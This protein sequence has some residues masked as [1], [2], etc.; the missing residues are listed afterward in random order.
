[1]L[2]TW[3]K[4]SLRTHASIFDDSDVRAR[5]FEDTLTERRTSV[6][7]R[8]GLNFEFR[9]GSRG[10]RGGGRSA[11]RA[12]LN[13]E[14]FISGLDFL[15]NTNDSTELGLHNQLRFPQCKDEVD[16]LCA[17]AQCQGNFLAL[18]YWGTFLHECNKEH[19]L[20][21]HTLSIDWQKPAW[22]KK[23][24]QKWH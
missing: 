12:S 1:M 13:S 23:V 5:V 6:E 19:S 18:E 16:R 8:H 7:P 15:R 24:K 22:V 14:H 17:K 3:A 20:K 2:Q 21:F 9:R 4:G 10:G 11:L